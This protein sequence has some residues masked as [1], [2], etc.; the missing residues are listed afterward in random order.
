M[1]STSSSNF[2]NE[3]QLHKWWNRLMFHGQLDFAYG[4][5]VHPIISLQT[6]KH[7]DYP[8]HFS[9]FSHIPNKYPLYKVYMG[10]IIKGPPSQGVSRIFPMILPSSKNSPSKMSIPKW[11]LAIFLLRKRQGEKLDFNQ[12]PQPI[13]PTEIRTKISSVVFFW[14]NIRTWTNLLKFSTHMVENHLYPLQILE[15]QLKFKWC[16]PSAT[17]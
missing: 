11:V 17:I 8:I 6:L 15:I 5:P 16:F 2:K 7:T 12:R 9:P 13:C 3:A 4:L 14:E 10:L 1:E